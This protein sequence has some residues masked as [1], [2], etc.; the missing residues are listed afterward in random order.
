VDW[1]AI[2]KFTC[3]NIPT[4]LTDP[5]ST[6]AP[7][8]FYRVAPLSVVPGPKLRFSGPLI[9]TNNLLT[10]ALDGVPGFTYRIDTSTN[11]LNWT[12]LTN[13]PATTTT[14]YFQDIITSNTARKFFRALAQ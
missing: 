10:L 9:P 3:T 8:R 12:P 6:N 14:T 4:V 5:A 13:F 11:L 2:L 1:T 7:R